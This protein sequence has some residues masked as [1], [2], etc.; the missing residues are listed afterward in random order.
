MKLSIEYEM[1][2]A[3]PSGIVVGYIVTILLEGK[4]AWRSQKIIKTKAMAEK[5]AINWIG[6][7]TV[8]NREGF[9]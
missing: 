5:A 4:V 3:Q 7:Q 2:T 1:Q 8:Q 6:I 9:K